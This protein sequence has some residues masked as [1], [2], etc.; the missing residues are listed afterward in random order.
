M[1]N[2]SLTSPH[3]SPSDWV[4][5]WWRQIGAEMGRWVIGAHI[6]RHISCDPDT[7]PLTPW[8]GCAG[9]SAQIGFTRN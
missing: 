8:T 6:F 3:I 4:A 9:D 2:Y 1:F 7:L 5:P